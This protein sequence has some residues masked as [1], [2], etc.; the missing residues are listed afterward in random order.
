M[1][2]L[3]NVVGGVLSLVVLGALAV[4]LVLMLRGTASGLAPAAQSFASPIERAF[5]SPIPTSR[6]TP[7]VEFVQPVTPTPLP[8]RGV[9][10]GPSREIVFSGNEVAIEQLYHGDLVGDALV[11]LAQTSNGRAIVAV[12]LQTGDA[13]VL[14]WDEEKRIRDLHSSESD[15][16]WTEPAPELGRD[17][18]E[19]HA[20]NRGQGSAS[21]VAR[22][23][24]LQLDLR[25]G[26][27]AWRGIRDGA[28]IIEG[29]DLRS[30]RA[31]TVAE[32][33]SDLPLYPRVCGREW[34]IYLRNS[35]SQK[36][37]DLYAHRL[38]TGDD[39][40]IGRVPFPREAQ[41]GEQHVC[42]G[43]RVAWIGQRTEQHRA[44]EGERTIVYPVPVYEQHLYDLST[45]T[46]RVLDTP[47][48]MLPIHVQLD[49][50]ILFSNISYD[51]RRDVPFSPCASFPYEQTIG[52]QVLVSSE[53]LL[54]ISG[55]PYGT[56][57]RRRLYVAPIVR[58]AV[59]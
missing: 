31:F 21:I 16:V 49:G 38:W 46:D 53:Q 42:D 29:Y 11:A 25:D 33:R 27:L 19:L 15:V 12:D 51:L 56:N 40:L 20:L 59:P 3:L 28:Q 13:S 5:D 41:V 57:V 50:D 1:K 39:V 17:A 36:T 58:D 24:I 6:E 55:I 44:E 45:R 30:G 4:V 8:D 43:D 48:R 14:A 22:G 47:V 34:V 32:A 52:G 18:V 37:A 23:H 7:R 10:A 54:L 35:S 2:R 26:V 9:R